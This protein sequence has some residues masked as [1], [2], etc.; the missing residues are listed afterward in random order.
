M[1]ATR[2]DGR[3]VA[4]IS[5]AGAREMPATRRD[6]RQVAVISR[7]GAREMPAGRSGYGQRMRR[8]L[9]WVTWL[10]DSLFA[11]L[12]ALGGAAAFVYAVIKGDWKIAGFAVLVT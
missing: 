4:V 3:Q 5:R 1:P 10:F 12:V 2:R 6:G 7:A 9:W 11:I 8:G